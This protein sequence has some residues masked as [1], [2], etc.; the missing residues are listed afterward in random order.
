VITGGEGKSEMM[1]GINEAHG[2]QTWNM[3]SW[4]V[5]FKL[6]VYGRIGAPS[7]NRPTLS[8]RPNPQSDIADA[9]AGAREFP[10]VRQRP[11]YN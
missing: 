9:E 3:S 4:Y 10:A 6:S 2:S 8:C 11:R 7:T 1:S 5:L